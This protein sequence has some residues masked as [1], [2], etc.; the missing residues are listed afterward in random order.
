MRHETLVAG[1]QRAIA[2]FG[3]RS[4]IQPRATDRHGCTASVDDCVSAV[5]AAS[6]AAES[7]A[8]TGPRDRGEVLRRAFEATR[9][10]R[11]PLARLIAAENAVYER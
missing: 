5:D 6:H 10:E 4:S 3:S 1:V 7:W 8:A 9:A 2:T 11:E